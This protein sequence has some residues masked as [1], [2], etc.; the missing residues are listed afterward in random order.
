MYQND[1]RPLAGL[2]RLFLLT[3]F[4]AETSTRHAGQRLPV[5]QGT[6]G[7]L[8][9]CLYMSIQGDGGAVKNNKQYFLNHFN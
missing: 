4:P 8:Q 5:K 3:V 9:D 6:L 2:F 7:S 1:C